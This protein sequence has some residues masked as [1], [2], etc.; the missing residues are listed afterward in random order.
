MNI[1]FGTGCVKGLVSNPVDT[2]MHSFWAYTP[3][4]SECALG[5]HEC[6]S[7]AR[8]LVPERRSPNAVTQMPHRSKQKRPE[9]SNPVP[10]KS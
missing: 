9:A 10:Q 6:P 2:L 4:G 1:W 5:H 8:I 7:V 3:R